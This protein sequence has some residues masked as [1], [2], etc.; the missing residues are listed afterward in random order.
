[1]LIERTNVVLIFIFIFSSWIELLF[2]L[3][4]L[5][6]YYSFKKWVLL[7]FYNV[8]WNVSVNFCYYSIKPSHTSMLFLILLTPLTLL[9]NK[10]KTTKS[11]C[12]L[13]LFLIL[14]TLPCPLLLET[15]SLLIIGLFSFQCFMVVCYLAM[16]VGF[17]C[18]T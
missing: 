13:S 14:R 5:M 12:E 9:K 2:L 15:I 3:L 1:M 4:N 16:E 8:K 6:F 10:T 11:Y 18:G 17:Q 7:T